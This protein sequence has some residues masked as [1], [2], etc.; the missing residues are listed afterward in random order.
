M[1]QP[2]QHWI[3]DSMRWR[4][5]VLTGKYAHWCFDY[6]DL[7]VDE[8]CDEWPCG[9]TIEMPDGTLVDTNQFRVG[10]LV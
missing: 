7:P 10:G 6:D 2:S 3:E 4:G 1:S 9:C 8:T 5:V